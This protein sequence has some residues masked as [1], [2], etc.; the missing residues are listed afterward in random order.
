MWYIL[1]LSRWGF[2]PYH[3]ARRFKHE[4]VAK[5]LLD[6]MKDTAPKDK[7]FTVEELDRKMNAMHVSSVATGNWWR[8]QIGVLV[9]VGDE[10]NPRVVT[11]N[12]E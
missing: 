5:I 2:T 8:R 12:G 9:G 10:G 4:N 3:D 7:P 11:R 1:S 6:H